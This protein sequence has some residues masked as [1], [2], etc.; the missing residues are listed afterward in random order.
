VSNG[1]R[2]APHY[3]PPNTHN[4]P[5]VLRGKQKIT[6]ELSAHIDAQLRKVPLPTA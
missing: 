1:A 5:Q 2:F 6:P 3:P 4:T